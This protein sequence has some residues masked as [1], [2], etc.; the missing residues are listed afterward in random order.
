MCWDPVA[1]LMATGVRGG[2][3]QVGYCGSL[4]PMAV[5]V[6]PIACGKAT[7][8]I[9]V[10]S[11]G[12]SGREPSVGRFASRLAWFHDPSGWLRLLRTPLGLTP[13]LSV[14]AVPS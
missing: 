12:C 7:K 10:R 1:V 5:G 9:Q 11:C 14:T 4:D 6:L 2:R 8:L 13:S 3:S